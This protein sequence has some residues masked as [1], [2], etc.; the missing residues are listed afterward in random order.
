MSGPN[1]LVSLPEA[2]ARHVHDG[3]LVFVGGFGQGVP[4]AAGREVIRQGRR[5]LTLC[6]TGAD[7]LFDILVAAGCVA[8][9]K[10]GWYGNPGIGLSHVLRR[11]VA[12]GSLTVEETSNFGLLLGLHAARLGVPFLPARILLDGDMPAHAP[13]LAQVVCPFTGE[14]LSAVAAIQPDV[15]LIHAQQADAA[16]NVQLWGIKGDTVEGAEAARR[17]IC[18]VERIVPSEV[19][20]EDPSRTV[21]A[22]NMV[23]SV[24]LAPMGAYP[25]YVEGVYGRDDAAYRAFEGLSRK[26]EALTDYIK[27]TV[28][29]FASHEEFV[30]ALRAERVTHV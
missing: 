9:V 27:S 11:A 1:K 23:T 3:D 15:A 24:A 8:S 17:V 14:T 13:G 22:A 30:A 26:P 18:T 21:L 29:A 2:V 28:H 20:A 25:S 6:R 12:D 7:I 5:N 16:G 19:I 4:F 10:F